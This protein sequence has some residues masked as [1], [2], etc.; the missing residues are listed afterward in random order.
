AASF[1]LQSSPGEINDVLID[2]HVIVD[3]D[4]GLEEGI[5]PALWEYYIAQFTTVETIVREF[6]RVLDTEEEYYLDPRSKTSFVFN[7]LTL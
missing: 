3:D 4:A 1:V 5:L 2:V 6:A 7:H